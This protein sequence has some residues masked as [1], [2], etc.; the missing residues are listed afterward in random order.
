MGAF[1]LAQKLVQEKNLTNQEMLMLLNECDEKT[2][3]YLRQIAFETAQ[4]VYGKTIFV[5]GL[6]EIS[7]Y[8]KNDCYYC[9]IRAGNKKVERYRL[10]KEQILECCE[11]GYQ[12]GFRTFV[13]QGGEDPYFTDERVADI[14]REIKTRYPDC[15]VTLSLGER[16][17]ESYQH[18]FE[19]GADRYLLRQETASDPHY[20][21]LHP[22]G[23]HLRDRMACQSALKEIGFQT[24]L[25]FMVG[26]PY[27]E[28]L[29]IVKDIQYIRDFRPHMVG[30]GPFLPHCDTPFGQMP[31]GSADKTLLVLSII[32]ILLP[33]VLLPATTALGT[34]EKDGIVQGVLHGAN[35]VMPNLSPMSV[36]KKYMLY[37]DKVSVGIQAAENLESLS[38]QLETIDYKIDFSRGDSLLK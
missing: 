4:K 22:H 18:L 14:I 31:K 23:M 5:R 24:G 13:M 6:I 1:E 10:S 20:E 36:R 30:I 32:R 8:C 19:A 21:S 29:H 7:N 38:K 3:E 17:R 26:S 33:E 25:G 34:V 15:A 2:H 12:L 27:Q 37:N 16:G 9:G 35:V 11:H 28:N